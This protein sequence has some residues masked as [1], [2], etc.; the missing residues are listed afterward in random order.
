M[1]VQL[2]KNGQKSCFIGQAA[3]IEHQPTILDPA[4]DGPGQIAQRCCQSI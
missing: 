2:G 1:T 3:K 4:Y